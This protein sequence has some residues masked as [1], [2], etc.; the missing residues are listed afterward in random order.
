MVGGMS[1]KGVKTRCMGAEATYWLAQ[2]LYGWQLV[3]FVSVC[4]AQLQR[5]KGGPEL[6]PR[7]WG[8]QRQWGWAH[9]E[10]LFSFPTGHETSANHLAFTVMELS[11]QPEILAR[12]GMGR[13][14]G[15]VAPLEASEG[16]V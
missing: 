14:V 5:E 15:G 13:L 7:A 1:F 12:Y 16:T 3:S 6:P 2:G 10:V 11:R 8:S 4:P 9:V